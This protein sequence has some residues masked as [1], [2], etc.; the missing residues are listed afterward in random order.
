MNIFINCLRISRVDFTYV[1]VAK[2]KLL[3]EVTMNVGKFVSYC[4]ELPCL[5]C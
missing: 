4:G 2:F 5:C 3:C 1:F